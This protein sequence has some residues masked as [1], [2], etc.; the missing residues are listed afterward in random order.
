MNDFSRALSFNLFNRYLPYLT[1]ISLA[2]APVGKVDNT[3]LPVILTTGSG[4]VTSRDLAIPNSNSWQ[5]VLNGDETS[6]LA[7][8]RVAESPSPSIGLTVYWEDYPRV[9]GA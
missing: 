2:E 7:D 6:G 8:I 9:V 3:N 4:V 1:A 5:L